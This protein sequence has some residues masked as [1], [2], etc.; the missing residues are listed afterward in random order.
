MFTRPRPQLLSRLRP[1]ILL[2][3]NI[4]RYSWPGI[5]AVVQVIAVVHVVHVDIVIVIPVVAPRIRPWIHRADPITAVLEAG[6]SAD[7]QEGKSLDA[8]SV[9]WPKVSAKPV[10]GNAV[11]AIASA[12][13]PGAMI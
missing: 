3:R 2:Q 12:L 6:I 13:L 5:A 10:F 7:H 8:K 11:A 9:V 4:D 1:V